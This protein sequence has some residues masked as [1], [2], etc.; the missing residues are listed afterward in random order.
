[1][2][3]YCLSFRKKKVSDKRGLKRKVSVMRLVFDMRLCT[4]MQ[5][6]GDERSHL[7]RLAICLLAPFCQVRSAEGDFTET[8]H[9]HLTLY[10]IKICQKLVSVLFV[11]SVRM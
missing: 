4:D 7:S 9:N 2:V 1:M 5:R 6:H 8:V 11:L 3:L 10:I